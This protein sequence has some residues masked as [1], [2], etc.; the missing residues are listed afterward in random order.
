[1]IRHR[2]AALVEQYPSVHLDEKGRA[3]HPVPGAKAFKHR[4]PFRRAHLAGA[5]AEDGDDCEKDSSD[6]EGDLAPQAHL[7]GGCPPLVDEEEEEVTKEDVELDVYTCM[8]C[9]EED[10][11]DHDI[12]KMCQVETTAFIAVG[13]VGG[14]VALLTVGFFAYRKLRVRKGKSINPS[15]IHDMDTLHKREEGLEPTYM[16]DP[17][18]PPIDQLYHDDVDGEGNGVPATNRNIT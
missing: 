4:K 10:I 9:L 13:V 14:V 17:M 6:E 5:E 15:N 18:P 7:A 12:A 8:I 16:D 2:A 11:E 1:M 3:S